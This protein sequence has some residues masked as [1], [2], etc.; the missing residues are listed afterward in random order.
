ME[1][2]SDRQRLINTVVHWGTLYIRIT[3]SLFGW[4][5]ISSL[6][7]CLNAAPFQGYLVG[8]GVCGWLGAERHLGTG[9]F[10]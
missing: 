7:L 5:L 2:Q 6:D 8:G 9:L 10:L 1:I 3:L 4:K